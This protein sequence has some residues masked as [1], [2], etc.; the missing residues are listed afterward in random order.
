M[1]SRAVSIVVPVY[2]GAR[3]L[4]DL[5][6]RTDAV[7]RDVVRESYEYVFVDDGSRDASWSVLESIASGRDDV[8]AIRLMRNFGQHNALM[9]GFKHAIGEVVV[10]ID[11]DLQNPPEEIPKLLEALRD[12][13]HDVVYGFFRDPRHGTI[14]NIASSAARW[15]LT[16]TIPGL[17][18]YY[19]N[20]RA[21]R[22]NVIDHVIEQRDDFLFI[23]GIITWI[24]D[25]VT[26]VPVVHDR[27]VSGRSNYTLRRLL[28]YFAIIVFTF[29]VLPLRILAAAGTLLS[30]TGFALGGYFLVRKLMGTLGGEGFAAIIVSVLTIGG[31]QL[32]SLAVLGEYVGKIFLK[33]SHKP[34]FAVRAYAGGVKQPGRGSFPRGTA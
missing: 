5:V 4:E 12:D 18:P 22:R 20:F 21:I 33:Q 1:S 28:S 10:T 26:H 9:C 3:S 31:L 32:L 23:D 30:L 6:A 15:L 13:T 29:T 17:H 8:C 14:R 11:D 24:T 2:N 16:R 27:R 34:Q 19:S 7:M 25:R